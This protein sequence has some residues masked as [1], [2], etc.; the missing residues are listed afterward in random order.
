LL[1]GVNSGA[2]KESDDLW[3]AAMKT[4]LKPKQSDGLSPEACGGNGSGRMRRLDHNNG[5]KAKRTGYLDSWVRQLRE[6]LGSTTEKDAFLEVA[7]GDGKGVKRARQ[8]DSNKHPVRKR[9]NL[10]PHFWRV[11]RITPQ[12]AG[13]WIL[14]SAI[15]SKA[16]G[17]PYNR[18]IGVQQVRE[19]AALIRKSEFPYD[20]EDRIVISHTEEWGFVVSN[21]QHRLA[22]IVL[23]NKAVTT[24][25]W[26]NAPLPIEEV[27]RRWEIADGEHEEIEE[28]K[29]LR[30][31]D[32]E[33]VK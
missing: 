6:Q 26:S 9:P 17:R 33:W 8:L 29:W 28:P 14:N 1:N 11:V 27:I 7:L 22:A 25:V 21:G 23:A 20:S 10:Q 18:P 13:Q 12:L 24:R 3:T 15:L 32:E 30:G 19:V 4:A 16:T 31:D 5:N 2:G